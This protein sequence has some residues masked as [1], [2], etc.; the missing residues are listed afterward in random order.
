[1]AQQKI[2]IGEE[3]AELLPLLALHLRNE[4]YDV[5]CARH[6]T[7]AL[8]MARRERPDLLLLSVSLP[9]GEGLTVL[10]AIGDYPDVAT[11]PVIY[12]LSVRPGAGKGKT[13]DLPDMASIR[14]P[15]ATGELIEKVGAALNLFE[16]AGF[17]DDPHQE[18]ARLESAAAHD[19]GAGAIRGNSR[20]R[21]A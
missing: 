15:V 1:M 6:G 14:K 5:L 18:A 8:E 11:I 4:Q 13:P 20:L 3:D 7:E 16:E 21:R 2:L 19:R 17:A 10:E 9:A 12:L